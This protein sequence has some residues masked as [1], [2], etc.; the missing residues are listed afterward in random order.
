MICLRRLFSGIITHQST[1]ALR[2]RVVSG[3]IFIVVIRF[4]CQPRLPESVIGGVDVNT[5]NCG[6]W[7]L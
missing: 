2:E 6:I 7:G 5:V 4:V 1:H 3:R